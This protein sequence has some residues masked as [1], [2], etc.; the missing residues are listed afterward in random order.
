MDERNPYFDKIRE[1]GES[2]MMRVPFFQHDLGKPE[3]DSIAEVLAG[4]ILTTGD[5]VAR[6][7][8]RFAKYMGSK[9]CLAVT[10]C[11]GALH[12]SLLALGIGP[13]DE[14]ITTPMTFIATS[15][16]IIEAGA[17]PVFVDVESNSGNLDASKIEA[18][19]TERT[20]A[21][22]PVHL[23]GQM[24]DMHAIRVLADRNKLFVIE[25]AAHCIEGSRD[26]IRPGQLGDAACFSFFATKNI[27]CGEGGAITTNNDTLIEKLRLLR[28]HGMTKN[29]NDRFREGYKHWDMTLLGWKYNM[30]NIQA[31]I[32]LPQ[33]DR[34]REKSRKRDDL[35]QLYEAK[36]KYLPGITLPNLLPGVVHARHLFTIW[37]DFGKRDQVI[38][39]LQNK[40]IGVTVNYRAIHLL[41]YFKETFGLKAGDFPEAEKIGN[42][43]ISLPFYPKMT[44][45][46]IDY[47][48]ESLSE[49]LTE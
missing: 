16:A 12:M 33:M 20:R 31:A 18:V 29:S 3:L 4:P 44:H 1:K 17:T 43:T 48:I 37:V 21:I 39:K 42:T 6:F 49:L 40:G 15:T 24:C 2:L 36:L 46:Q 28:L 38:E 47:V 10:S 13:G 34:V 23:Y 22:L 35:A 5:T 30:D 19:I 45:D 41:S 14:V 25:D 27:T 32:L 11:T 26:G 7:E 8:Q 9:H